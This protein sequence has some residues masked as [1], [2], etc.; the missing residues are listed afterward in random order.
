MNPLN[1]IYGVVSVAIFSAVGWY[2]WQCED[3]KGFKDK[4]VVLAEKARDEAVATMVLY[5]QSKEKADAEFKKLRADNRSLSERLSSERAR[6]R[7]LSA[8][9]TRAP[10]P[11]RACFKGS[12]LDA[13]VTRLIDETS[14]TNTDLDRELSQIV[15]LGQDAVSALDSVKVWAA[16]LPRTKP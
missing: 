2:V 8:L 15:G 11:E 13:A 16:T 7:S 5:R 9:A 3:A 1:V 6:S 10:S 14:A 4:A 12:V